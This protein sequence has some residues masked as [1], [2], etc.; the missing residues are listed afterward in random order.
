MIKK[1]KVITVRSYYDSHNIPFGSHSLY[2]L[3]SSQKKNSNESNFYLSY[4]NQESQNWYGL[5]YEKKGEMKLYQSNISGQQFQPLSTTTFQTSD[6]IVFDKNNI[7]S[8]L[9]TFEI[10]K[11]VEDKYLERSKEIKGD[12]QLMSVF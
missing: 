8:L 10:P 4:E 12:Y 11:K 9:E 6:Y 1:N 2:K 3:Y 5:K 7:D